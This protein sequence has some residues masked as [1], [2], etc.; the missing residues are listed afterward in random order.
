MTRIQTEQE[1]LQ[2]TYGPALRNFHSFAVD[3]MFTPNLDIMP[4]CSEGATDTRNFL[5]SKEPPLKEDKKIRNVSWKKH[6]NRFSD[7][8]ASRSICF[9]LRKS[10]SVNRKKICLL[11]AMVATPAMALHPKVLAVCGKQ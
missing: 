4:G 3:G 9:F 11:R 7:M 8:M 5:F 1:S 6:G 2:L 10:G